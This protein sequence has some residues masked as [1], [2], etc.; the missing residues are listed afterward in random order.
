MQ[1]LPFF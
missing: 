1:N